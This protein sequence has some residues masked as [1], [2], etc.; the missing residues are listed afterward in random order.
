M[1]RRIRSQARTS[2]KVAGHDQM[3]PHSD[4]APQP[5]MMSMMM[6]GMGPPL[7]STMGM[8]LRAGRSASR[9]PAYPMCAAIGMLRSCSRT[10][11]IP[12]RGYMSA[13][14][15]AST[16]PVASAAHATKSAV[17][18]LANSQQDR[19]YSKEFQGVQEGN[20]RDEDGDAA[21]QVPLLVL[22]GRPGDE[23]HHHRDLPRFRK[24]LSQ[25]CICLHRKPAGSMCTRAG[26]HAEGVACGAAHRHIQRARDQRQ[27]CRVPCL[28]HT[29]PPISL[30]Q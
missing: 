11:G 5:A 12:F 26:D 17:Q 29:A 18:Q 23:D 8:I 19:H 24:L 28:P 16:Y 13:S 6:P 2:R 4:H 30:T 27:L 20:A 15:H 22:L 9:H 7:S 14:R 25:S 1:L 3:G 21:V 10:S